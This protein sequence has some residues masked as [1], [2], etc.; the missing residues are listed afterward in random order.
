MKCRDERVNN[1]LAK[2]GRIIT[3]ENKS[4]VK[5]AMALIIEMDASIHYMD[6]AISSVQSMLLSSA[7]TLDNVQKDVET[8]G[9]K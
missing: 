9:C 5:E 4:D 7:T 6:K 8:C 2:L 1:A 3:P